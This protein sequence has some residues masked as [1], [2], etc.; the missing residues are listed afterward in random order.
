M[1]LSVLNNNLCEGVAICQQHLSLIHNMQMVQAVH[2]YFLQVK[3]GTIF[4]NI[5]I[6]DDPDYAEKFGKETW[7]K[8]KDAEKKMKESQEEEERKSREEEEKKKKDEEPSKEDDDDD[9]EEPDEDTEDA[10]VPDKDELQ[11]V[12]II[13]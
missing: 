7:G 1:G 3:S 2:F 8:T 10:D 4:D 9:D 11:T 12:T 13:S 6:T 5:L